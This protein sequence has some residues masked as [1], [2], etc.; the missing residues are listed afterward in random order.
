MVRRSEDLARYPGYSGILQVTQRIFIDDKSNVITQPQFFLLKFRHTH[1]C[2]F[3]QS[4]SR[5]AI[6]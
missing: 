2:G 4:R 6:H 1:W 5:S 3:I